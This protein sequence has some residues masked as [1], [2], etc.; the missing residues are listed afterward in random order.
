MESLDRGRHLN[1]ISLRAGRDQIVLLRDVIAGLTARPKRLPP[2]LLLRQ[3]GRTAVRGD[4]CA[5]TPA[6]TW[7]QR[8]GPFTRPDDSRGDDQLTQFPRNEANCEK[9]IRMADL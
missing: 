9:V 5:A 2:K 4:H 3:G 6:G 7:R 1:R 8:N